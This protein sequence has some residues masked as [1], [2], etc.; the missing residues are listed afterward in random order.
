MPELVLLTLVLGAYFLPWIVASIRNHP[1]R[2]VICLVNLLFG[3]TVV[4][5]WAVLAWSLLGGSEAG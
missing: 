5:W 4:G 3:W 1:Q 2:E